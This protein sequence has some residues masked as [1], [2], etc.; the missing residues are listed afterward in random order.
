[1]DQNTD[2]W[3]D[4]RR[5]RIGASDVAAILGCSPYMDKV[6]LWLDK[7]GQAPPKQISEFAKQRG[8]EV[9]AQLRARYSLHTGRDYQ[10]RLAVHD[11]YEFISAS[12]DGYSET[13]HAIEVKFVGAKKYQEEIIPEHHII[14]MQH[15]MLVTG[16]PYIDYLYSTDGIEYKV[17]KCEAD[18][19]K[20]AL[21]LKECLEFWSYVVTRQEPPCDKRKKRRPK[22]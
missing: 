13:G 9:E 2:E 3:L 20:Q 5:Q 15:Q 10:P 1:V 18:P 21:I 22:K 12:L 4:W 8:G 6:E 7:T 11:E 16:L 19:D 17:F 14:Q